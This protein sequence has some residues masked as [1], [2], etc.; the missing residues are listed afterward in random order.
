MLDGKMKGIFKH[1]QENRG[2]VKCAANE[3]MGLI[4]ALDGQGQVFS[5]K[6][7]RAKSV[8]L[9]IAPKQISKMQNTSFVG[10][11]NSKDIF[12]LLFSNENILVAS[13]KQE[14][15]ILI[16]SLSSK[17]EENLS[18]KGPFDFALKLDEE[19]AFLVAKEMCTILNI[20]NGDI[21]VFPLKE[22][23]KQAAGPV[24]DVKY[25]KDTG[26]MAFTVKETIV[27]WDVKSDTASSKL[28]SKVQ[29][30]GKLENTVDLSVFTPDGKYLALAVK[31][32]LYLRRIK[33]E[34]LIAWYT[35]NH[36]IT[37]IMTSDNSWYILVATADRR[38]CAFIIADPDCPDHEDRIQYARSTN[39][40]FSGDHA[41]AA[42]GAMNNMV[43]DVDEVRAGIGKDDEEVPKSSD[44]FFSSED[45]EGSKYRERKA[46]FVKTRKTQ[47]R[48]PVNVT[49]SDDD[50]DDG[51][52]AEEEEDSSVGDDVPIIHS[53]PS[54]SASIAI[55]LSSKEPQIAAKK[56]QQV[57]ATS[58]AK[59]SKSGTGV[60]RRVAAAGQR[61]GTNTNKAANEVKATAESKS[62]ILL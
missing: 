31:G 36:K 19:K 32:E 45:E 15:A 55:Y 13:R 30:Y 49:Y 37:S 33:D 16:K 61:G 46:R 11:K 47:R 26:I 3:N 51:L 52:A 9:Q 41:V 27:L 35:M 42:L 60:D 44:D 1:P 23:L 25:A 56:P 58:T 38:F 10:A 22:V 53:D 28:I 18:V 12:L 5:W 8:S 40:P 62:C 39:I 7:A 50:S 2:F 17:N 21:T 20:G 48:G 24:T 43:L 4:I 29:H 59:S 54:D 57:A 34:K 14:N 6:I